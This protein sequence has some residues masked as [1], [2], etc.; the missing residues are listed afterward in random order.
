MREKEVAALLHD[1]LQRNEARFLFFQAL[2]QDREGFFDG[3][4]VL[5]CRSLLS[6]GTN[7]AIGEH[8]QY[9]LKC[10]LPFRLR[11]QHTARHF[12]FASPLPI[13][14]R[15]RACEVLANLLPGRANTITAKLIDVGPEHG[16]CL[17]DHSSGWRRVTARR[18]P[19]P[20]LANAHRRLR[21]GE[22]DCRA[23]SSLPSTNIC[24]HEREYSRKNA[25]K[26][27]GMTH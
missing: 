11:T 2:L 10:F 20:H 6:F 26:Q 12:T 17:I 23:S 24:P 4:P 27:V 7:E 16:E 19:G 18:R 15:G 5:A 9:P 1:I 21:V 3:L 22:Y 25:C 14:M 13:T 8:G